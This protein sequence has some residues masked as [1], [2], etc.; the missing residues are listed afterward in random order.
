MKST[1]LKDQFS[2]K[3][4]IA[5]A[6]MLTV[7]PAAA[8]AADNDASTTSTYN[9]SVSSSKECAIDYNSKSVFLD[10]PPNKLAKASDVADDWT[11]CH[12]D[13]IAIT[14]YMGTDPRNPSKE[15]LEKAISRDIEAAGDVDYRLFFAQN[16]IPKSKISLHDEGY[17][18]TLMGLSGSKEKIVDLVEAKEWENKKFR[19]PNN[20][21]ALNHE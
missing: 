19:Q 13:S 1:A 10:F 2:N 6:T 4:A 16:D 11:K 8:N 15:T 18:L 14:I 12:L 20:S 21:I 9:S 5:L 17:T 7:M 3:A